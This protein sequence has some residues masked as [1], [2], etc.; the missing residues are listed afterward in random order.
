[1]LE[2]MDLKLFFSDG[3]DRNLYKKII[4]EKSFEIGTVRMMYGETDEAQWNEME[5]W[6][7]KI[8]D[9]V[10]NLVAVG[11]GGNINKTFRVLNLDNDDSAGFD[12]L[13]NFHTLLT[14][15]TLRERIVKLKLNPDRAD[16]IEP[17]RY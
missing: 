16:V 13:K 1:M 5:E 15:L 10:K 2:I 3:S 17:D 14:E 12:K 11:T 8:T 6:V 9:D 4:G 7:K